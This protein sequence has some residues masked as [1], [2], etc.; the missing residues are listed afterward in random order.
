[1]WDIVARED[2]VRAVE[3]FGVWPVNYMQILENSPDNV[4]TGILHGW[5]K[6]GE[7]SDIW[8]EMPTCS[9]EENEYGIIERAQRTQYL[10]VSQYLMPTA[11]RLPQPWPGAKFHWPRHSALW[12][13][14]MDDHHTMVFS[15]VFTPFKDGQVPELPPGMTFDITAQLTAHRYQDYVAICSQGNIM[16]RTTEH[17]AT[18]D[19][20]IILLRKLIRQGIEAVA[21]G[22]DPKGVWRTGS[23]A[24]IDL[25]SIVKDETLI[26]L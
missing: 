16:D 20:G 24:V 5:G 11:N 7:R 18:S 10:R 17:L 2:G 1:M 14:P 15:V 4:H 8:E 12:R 9:W 21:E 23:D 6:E 25:T 19:E 13:T 22:R 26:Q 3:N